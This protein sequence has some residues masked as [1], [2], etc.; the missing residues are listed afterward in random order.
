[1][2]VPIYRLADR[3]GR[4]AI[5][6]GLKLGAAV[7]PPESSRR[8]KGPTRRSPFQLTLTAKQ[9]PA[10]VLILLVNAGVLVGATL[11][12]ERANASPAAVAAVTVITTP[13]PHSTA[14]P[15][16]TGESRLVN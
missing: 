12:I 11:L 16:A 9:M 6:S 2:L 7:V 3:F 1:M 13:P 5:K 14:Q 15:A 8:R 4:V 10:L